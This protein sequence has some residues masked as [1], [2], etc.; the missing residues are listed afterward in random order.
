MIDFKR[1]PLVR[2]LF[3]GKRTEPQDDPVAELQL[4][5]LNDL[6]QVS[7]GGSQP[8]LPTQSPGGSWH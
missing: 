8:T 6:K 1:I 2:F 3:E 7:G 4:V 5:D